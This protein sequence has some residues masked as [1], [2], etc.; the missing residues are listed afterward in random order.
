MK[1]ELQLEKENFQLEKIQIQDLLNLKDLLRTNH[2]KR[3]N[4]NLFI[5]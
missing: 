3:N 1:E 5:R 4:E 2:K